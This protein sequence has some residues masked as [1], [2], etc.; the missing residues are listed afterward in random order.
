[1]D[2]HVQNEDWLLDGMSDNLKAILKKLPEDQRDYVMA[3]IERA[4]IQALMWGRGGTPDWHL[5][6]KFIKEIRE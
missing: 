2:T 3:K 5:T 6:P 4:A 1:M